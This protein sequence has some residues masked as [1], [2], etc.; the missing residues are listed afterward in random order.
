MPGFNFKIK[1]LVPSVFKS[2]PAEKT[3]W[4]QEYD[5]FNTFIVKKDPSIGAYDGG[6]F[7]PFL[8]S[9]LGEN[10]TNPDPGGAGWRNYAT[11]GSFSSNISSNPTELR[12]T[13]DN[14]KWEDASAEFWYDSSGIERKSVWS[15]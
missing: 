4:K 7:V 2:K 5:P 8:N 12:K 13:K 15:S 6:S 9:T 3:S 10:N 1:N 11:G 14:H